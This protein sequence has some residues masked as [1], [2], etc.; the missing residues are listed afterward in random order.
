MVIRRSDLEPRRI[1]G[2][3]R[4]TH[5]H[6]GQE[7]ATLGSPLQPP[8]EGRAEPGT[9]SDGNRNGSV[10]VIPSPSGLTTRHFP[11]VTL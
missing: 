5:A 11:A 6:A 3:D 4:C 1:K 10:S 2:G 7:Y 9:D 8:P